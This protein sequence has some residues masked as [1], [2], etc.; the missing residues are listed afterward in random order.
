MHYERVKVDIGQLMTFTFEQTQQV[1]GLADE[2]PY[3]TAS[4]HEKKIKPPP[5]ICD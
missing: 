1:L 5:K 2:I 3:S 4:G